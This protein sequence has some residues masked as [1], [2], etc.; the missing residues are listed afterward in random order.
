MYSCAPGV[1]SVNI[2]IRLV[3]LVVLALVPHLVL[4]GLQAVDQFYIYQE[5]EVRANQDYAAA[6]ATAFERYLESIWEAEMAM[7]AAIVLRQ[8]ELGA[9][10]IARFLAQQLT[11]GDV[12]V[13]LTWLNPEGAAISCTDERTCGHDLSDLPQIAAILQGRETSLS[14]LTE[15]PATKEPVVMVSRGIKLNGKLQGIVVATLD[16]TRLCQV[17]PATRDAGRIHGLVDGA[18]T[19][20]YR[21]TEPH[22]PVEMRS[23]EE[24]G[25]TARA[26]QS[27]AEA[28]LAAF[29]GQKGTKQMGAVELIPSIGWIAFASTPVEV[30]TAEAYRHAARYVALALVADLVAVAAIL[31]FARRL[32]RPVAEL[33]QAA[34]AISRGDLS[35][36]V[37]P[38]GNDEIAVAARAF[39]QMADWMQQSEAKLRAQAAQ[40]A[41]AARLGFAALEGTSLDALLDQAV[42][43]LREILDV[44][45]CTVLELLPGDDELVLRAGCGWRRGAV[46]SLKVPVSYG[47]QAGYALLSRQ[48]VIV[49]DLSQETRF[50]APL[51]AK[52]GIVSG[53]S[54]IIQGEHRPYGVLGVHAAKLRSFTEDDLH[55]L[56]SVANVVAA[57]MERAE[58][59]RRFMV[60]YEV[61]RVLAQSGSITVALSRVLQAVCEGLD[62]EMGAF[63]LPDHEA[64][65]LRCQALWRSRTLKAP[66]FEEATLRAPLPLN[67]G[68]PAMV[69]A[70]GGEPQWLDPRREPSLMRSAEAE[71]D[72]IQTAVGFP[73]MADEVVG[74]IELVS[75]RA[76]R[77]DPAVTDLMRVVGGL[78]AQFVERKRA[79]EEL[80]RVNAALEERVADR[81][82]K[83]E[84]AVQE[85]EAFS[86]SV[87]HDLQGPLRSIEGFAA[88]LEEDAFSRLRPE[89]RE[90]LRRIGAAV[91]QMKRLIQDLLRLSQLA[92]KDLRRR[93]VD[94]SAVAR[95]VAAELQRLHPDQTRTTIRIQ[96]GMWTYADAGLV[97]VALFNLMENAWK[98]TSQRPHPL[99]EVGQTQVDGETAF[100]VRD[101]GVGFNMDQADR[102]FQPFKRLHPSG[103]YQG[104][105][106]GL[107]TVQRIVRSHG[108]QVWAESREGEGAVF[109]FTLGPKAREE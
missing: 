92:R 95:A 24:L 44:E 53:M 101:N 37:H 28:V 54:V 99:I 79:E 23:A 30:V 93:R 84:V 67:Q 22:L 69:F 94:L 49:N 46:G 106:I 34:L 57:A 87:S 21:S 78:V 16:V 18:G 104:S 39:N 77:H 32:L 71:Q 90:H 6:V 36:R 100:Y 107:A 81:T 8:G 105:G 65:V 96:D 62:W 58:A 52:M 74:I 1:D 35:A 83:L 68:V 7:G 27:R 55:F 26:L 75:A 12:V 47:S 38:Q 80:R 2:R 86:Y 33:E 5:R 73:V 31:W 76:R 66:H 72:G 10:E 89:E 82:H 60:Q 19:L 15:S 51:L 88:A 40:Q 61:A 108:G 25:I 56:Q 48:P 20:V 43:V 91:R 45:Y 11:A 29:E 64:G 14:P 13:R 41:A 50:Q 70:T 97:H 59:Q 9:D 102:L 98:F 17:L 63:W 42:Q 4:L 3:I 103:A 85:L 109:F